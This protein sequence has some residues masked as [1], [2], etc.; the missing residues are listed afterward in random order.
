MLESESW[1]RFINYVYGV[2]EKRLIDEEWD[3]MP[4]SNN[5]MQLNRFTV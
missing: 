2:D 4:Q 5:D 3:L 1:R